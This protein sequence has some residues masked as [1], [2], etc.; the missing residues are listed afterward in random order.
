M[1]E[2]PPDPQPQQLGET[3]ILAALQHTLSAE[4]LGSNHIFPVHLVTAFTKVRQIS[5]PQATWT[6]V[7]VQG[8]ES[9]T[10]TQR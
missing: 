5:Y 3:G 9:S 8:W 4:Q 10:E 6:L 1:R 7:Q 2:A